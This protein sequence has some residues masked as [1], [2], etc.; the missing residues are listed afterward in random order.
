MCEHG[1]TLD[2]PV[3]I[4]AED[5]HTG[6]ERVAIKPIDACIAELVIAL[7]G[8]KWRTKSSCCGHGKGLGG[9]VL[10]DGRELTIA[11]WGEVDAMV[12]QAKADAAEVKRLRE[13][14]RTH[15][16][17]NYGLKGLTPGRFEIDGVSNDQDRM[18]YQAVLE[19]P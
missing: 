5:S 3:L 12:E 16:R 1:D 19:A 17:E 9:I 8:S 2:V 10:L 6:E 4:C 18:L 7:N 11:K 15:W 13:L 14:I